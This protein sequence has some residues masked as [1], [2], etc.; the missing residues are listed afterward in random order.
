MPLRTQKPG[1]GHGFFLCHLYTVS[2]WQSLRQQGIFAN[3]LFFEATRIKMQSQRYCGMPPQKAAKRLRH[4]TAVYV[5]NIIF[6]TGFRM[7]SQQQ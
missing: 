7:C 2:Q 5:R 4:K 6:C 3:L 1:K